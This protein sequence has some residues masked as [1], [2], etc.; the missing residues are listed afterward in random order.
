[1]IEFLKVA[2]DKPGRS[3]A[4]ARIASAIASISSTEYFF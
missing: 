4:K 3:C 2:A 1:M